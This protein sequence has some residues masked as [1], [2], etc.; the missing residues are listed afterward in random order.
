VEREEAISKLRDELAL[1]QLWDDLYCG[2][3][4]NLCE[5]AARRHRQ[6]RRQEILLKLATLEN[7]SDGLIPHVGGS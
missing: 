4:H 3:E 5:E 6:M 7:S 2:R 1:I